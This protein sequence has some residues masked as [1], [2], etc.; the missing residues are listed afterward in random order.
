MGPK[1]YL[2][3]IFGFQPTPSRKTSVHD[4]FRSPAS[5][6]ETYE[7]AY[8]RLMERLDVEAKQKEQQDKEYSLQLQL[9]KEQEL[10]ERMHQKQL[11]Q[12]H[13]EIL[14]RQSEENHR[15]RLMQ[16]SF[17]LSPA[18]DLSSFPLVSNEEKIS[19][20][21]KQQIMAQELDRQMR[22]KQKRSAQVKHLDAEYDACQVSVWK[23][24]NEIQR[25]REMQE[26]LK[27]RDELTKSWS[28]N[29]RAKSIMKYIEGESKALPQNESNLLD[30]ELPTVRK[31]PK[32]RRHP[33]AIS[34]TPL[35]PI[36]IK[37][38]SPTVPEFNKQTPISA[39]RSMTRRELA[40]QLQE[41]IRQNEINSLKTQI[42][43]RASRL[44]SHSPTAG[45][46]KKLLDEAAALLSRVQ[47]E[48]T[49]RRKKPSSIAPKLDPIAVHELLTPLRK[50]NAQR[51]L[52]Q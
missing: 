29:Q 47:R 24:Q 45:Y 10:L 32:I 1:Q 19:K 6:D 33:E 11:Q 31:S 5:V 41:Q 18:F 38:V 9:A 3:M 26:R 21:Q 43:N 13:A 15:K 50:R 16:R 42:S 22:D 2:L 34:I 39:M 40:L 51:S 36:E 8:Q 49:I 23:S 14:R 37:P 52:S 46:H 7:K 25:L 20:S 4:G 30:S 27:V 35:E 44:S 48:G 12:A 28:D 17:D